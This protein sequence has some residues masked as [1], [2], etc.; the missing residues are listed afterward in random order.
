MDELKTGKLPTNYG[1]GFDKRV[2]NQNLSKKLLDKKTK[3]LCSKLQNIDA[4]KYSL[5]LQIWWRDHKEADKKRLNTEIKKYKDDIVRKKA[6]S[7]LTK[8]ERELLGL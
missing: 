3:E 7:K 6:L 5:E 4:T 2:Y 8:Y 1:D